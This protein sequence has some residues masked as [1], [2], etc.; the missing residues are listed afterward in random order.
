MHEQKSFPFIS[1]TRWCSFLFLAL[2]ISVIIIPRPV[3]ADLDN[4]QDTEDWIKVPIADVDGFFPTPWACG[5]TPPSPQSILQF[6]QNWHCSNHDGVGPNWGN[7][8]FGFHKQFLLGY[9]RFLASKGEV[10]VKTW[11]PGPNVPIPPAHSGRPKN[12]PC[13]SCTPLPTSFLPSSLGGT[14]DNIG[15]VTEIGNEIV[16]WHNGIHFDIAMAGGSG[17]CGG[18]PDMGCIAFAPRDPIFYRYHHI[19]DD[20][21][22]AWRT[23]QPTD[24]A[25]VLDRSG[26]MSLPTKDGGTRL[27]AAKQA[28]ALFAD[29]LEDNKNHKLGMVSFSTTA[30]DPPDMPLTNVPGAPA[31]ISQALSGLVADGFTS[32]GDGLQKAQTLV[33]SG[34]EARKAILL[35]TDGMENTNPSITTILPTLGDTHV[36]SIGLGTPGTIDGPKL[37]DLSERQ[38]GIYITTPNGLELKKFFV[39]CFANIFDTFPS[40]D[41]IDTLPARQSVSAPTVHHA[42][43]DEKI[44]FVLGWTHPAPP[45]SLML[46]ITTPL[47]NVL[48]LDASGVE[49]KF[50]PTWHIVRINTPYNGERDGNWTA[51]VVRPVRTY[52]NGFSSRSFDDFEQGVSLV[53]T[54]LTNLCTTGCHNILYYED[55]TTSEGHGF[56]QEHRTVYAAAL[57]SQPRLGSITRPANASEFRK[58]L[59]GGHGRFDLLVYSSQYN[60]GEQPYDQ[61]LANILCSNGTRAIISDNRRTKGAQEILRCAG[62]IRGKQTNFKTIVSS[63][64][65]VLLDRPANF[66]VPDGVHDFSYELLPVNGRVSQARSTTNAVAVVVHA[67]QGRS[68]ER[69]FITVLTRSTTKL[70][71][72]N[73]RNNTYTLEDLHPTFHIPDM[74]W[75]TCGFDKVTAVVNVTRPL[76]SLAKLLG[77]VR[78]TNG[79]TVQ[80]D[81][82]SPR[83]AAALTLDK[84]GVVI[85]TETKQFSLYDDG[86]HGDSTANDHYWEVSLPPNFTAVDGDYHLHAFFRLCKTESCGRQS[87]IERE[88]QQSITIR[89][90]M[91]S[92]SKVVVTRESAHG[93]RFRSRILITPADK[94]GTPLGPGLVDELLIT[95]VGD[96][97]VES[98]SDHDGSG[99][100]KIMVNWSNKKGDKPE[101]IIAQFGR[102]KNAIHVKL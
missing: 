82:L 61:V 80:G 62:A 52:V 9:N 84:K 14:L 13:A 64:S 3:A 67:E 60:N 10:N 99:T 94:N 31:A 101:V 100:Y 41:P 25:I 76:R 66:R 83:A 56:F 27:D 30:S 39:M 1:G 32:I 53:R 15:S 81:K 71:P 37:R 29:L 12:T 102:P 44:V 2:A 85:P 42:F 21:Q 59:E 58:A 40:E 72:F 55:A 33:S 22:D 49:S 47:G 5:T 28:A 18:S 90:Q 88:A 98:A 50:G 95:T 65:S 93:D 35:L 45:R 75:P 7:R 74:Y 51:R 91:S 92:A 73:H 69:Y 46:A 54:E 78:S 38:G 16:D 4:E 86:T 17:G 34:P 11:V 63:D 19:F 97:K 23:L 20:V 26:S 8:F 77:S 36:C 43:L 68:D 70:K 89:A 48:H 87:C 96:V 57:L 79:S 24:I 6:H